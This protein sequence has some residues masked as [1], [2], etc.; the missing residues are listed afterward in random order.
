MHWNW[1]DYKDKAGLT[2]PSQRIL[3]PLPFG[4]RKQSLRFPFQPEAGL[5][6]RDIM[7]SPVK[8]AADAAAI[9]RQAPTNIKYKF[10]GA[11]G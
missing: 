3:R 4:V 11:A 6:H 10:V 1:R 5:W 2:N 7:G 8:A 9:Q